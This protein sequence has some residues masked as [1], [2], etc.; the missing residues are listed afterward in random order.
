MLCLAHTFLRESGLL[1]LAVSPFLLKFQ[2]GC[3]F[4]D[5]DDQLPLPCVENSRYLTFELL[6]SLMAT[7]GFVETHKKWK[8]GGKMAYWLYRKA[9]KD[10]RL[11]FGPFRKRTTCRQGNSRN[12]FVILVQEQ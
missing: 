1:F 6:Q 10:S 11:D 4:D 2:L 7:I 5:L 9:E 3:L 12:N 8:Q